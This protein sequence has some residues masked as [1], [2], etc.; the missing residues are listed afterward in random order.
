MI[1]QL[2]SPWFNGRDSRIIC[3]TKSVHEE[4]E[5]TPVAHSALPGRGAETVWGPA[6]LLLER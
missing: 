3:L 1:G 5:C 6:I 2:L 4:Q